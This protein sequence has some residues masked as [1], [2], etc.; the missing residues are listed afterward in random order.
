MF[1]AALFYAKQHPQ[2]HWIMTAALP[3]FL[4]EAFF[5]LGSVFATPR[6]WFSLMLSKRLQGLVLWLSALMPYL[7]FASLAGTLQRNAIEVLAFLTGVL[8]FWYLLL[9][10]RVA[11][12][13]GFL[14]VAAAP[15]VLRIFP[16]LYL[17][18]DP[19]PQ[20]DVLG[21]LM[22]IR[23]GIVT[24]LVFREWD[25]GAFG[26]WPKAQEWRVGFA[27]YAA[28]LIPLAIVAVPLH[29]LQFAP[30]RGEWWKITGL[31]IATFFG[32][33]WVLALGEELFFRG[34]IER[35]FLTKWRSRWFA[36][37]LSALLFGSAHLWFHHFPNWQRGLVATILG[38]A[39]GFAYAQSGGVR[40][41][42]VTHALVVT[43]GKL[44]FR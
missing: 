17:A 7:I 31:A 22:W 9:P 19:R 11:Y 37:L 26:L 1:T 4:I 30:M 32:V 42:M 5:Y 3:A 27:C 16:R 36:I 24:L 8:A 10:R 18:P 34:V 44:L 35:A 15:M 14:L 6:E 25:P 13:V 43:T 28:A 21:H 38:I 23:L 39:C 12:D 20:I 33:L 29:D 40:A 41:P 2:L